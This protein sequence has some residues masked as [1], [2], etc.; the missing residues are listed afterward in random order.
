MLHAV[1]KQYFI[2]ESSKIPRFQKVKT[3][4]DNSG[5]FTHIQLAGW[6]HMLEGGG[7]KVGT[8]VKTKKKKIVVKHIRK[9]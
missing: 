2:A 3:W 4:L 8:A 9:L 5:S 1:S 7:G 6:V